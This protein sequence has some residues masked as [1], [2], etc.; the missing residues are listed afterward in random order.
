MFLQLFL[1]QWLQLFLADYSMQWPIEAIKYG[2]RL[3]TSQEWVK[4]TWQ[5][6]SLVGNHLF[7]D[8]CERCWACCCITRRQGAMRM[9]YVVSFRKLMKFKTLPLAICFPRIIWAAVKRWS[10]NFIYINN[11]FQA[12]SSTE[13]WHIFKISWS[14]PASSPLRGYCAMSLPFGT[15]YGI[16]FRNCCQLRWELWFQCE[17]YM[18]KLPGSKRPPRQA[19]VPIESYHRQNLPLCLSHTSVEDSKLDISSFLG[20]Q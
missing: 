8:S 12:L 1:L 17:R 15:Q 4:P 7:L 9:W 5:W 3:R 6:R 14:H 2:K 11:D 19:D 10:T 13:V 18:A 20:W 16:L